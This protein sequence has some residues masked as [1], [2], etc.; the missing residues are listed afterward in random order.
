MKPSSQHNIEYFIDKF[1]FRPGFFLE[2]GCWHGEH[3]SQTSYLE[4][5]KKWNGLCVDPFPSGFEDRTC[6]VCPKAI[7]KDG[8]K[9]DFIKVSIDRRYGGDVSYFSGFKD[10][11]KT[12]LPLIQNHCD[13]EEVEVETIT[14]DELYKKYKL[15]LY[16]EFLSVD[17][18]GSEQE[19][20]E[21]IDF[22]LYE[23]GLIIFE[24]NGVEEVKKAIAKILVW[25]GYWLYKSLSEDDIYIHGNLTTL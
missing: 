23:Y 24:H 14:I 17:T 10:T 21:S 3:I 11:L 20:F 9:R 16:I 22:K 12:H 5:V 7:S 2:L 13:Y 1:F 19:I 15:P 25:N 6:R 8:G 4:K 18:E